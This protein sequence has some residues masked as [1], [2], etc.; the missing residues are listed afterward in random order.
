MA[1][2]IG[3]GKKRKERID[4]YLALVLL[5]CGA[6]VILLPIAFVLITS[7]KTDVE[8]SLMGFQW[9][10]STVYF[11]NYVNAWNME[12]WPR[13]FLNSFIMTGVTVVISLLINT[14]AGFAFSRIKFRGREILFIFM[15]MGMMVPAQSIIIPQFIIIKNLNLYDSFPAL[16]IP[17]LSAPMGIFLCRQYYLSFPESLDEAARIDG[18]N[19]FQTY[20][21]IFLPLSKTLLATLTILKAVQSWNNFFYPLI[22]TT[23]EK[24]RTIQLGLQMFKGSVATHYN[25]LMAAALF[26]SL[27]IVLV[28]LLAQKYFIAGIQNSG[29]K[30]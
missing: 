7:F 10:P 19:Y 11:G 14:M 9:L 18:C 24:M 4:N 16:I 5:I 28:Y 13:L 30:N 25:W 23:S 20:Y 12:N 21:R 8:I 1:E 15:L 29:M 2:T 3:M 17:F 26:T 22:F 27:P 6:V